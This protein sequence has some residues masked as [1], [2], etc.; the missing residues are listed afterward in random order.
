MGRIS[1]K[2]VSLYIAVMLS[3]FI[4]IS[5][6]EPITEDI[7]A[8]V[9]DEGAPTI[10]VTSPSNYSIYK[11]T[12][13]FTGTVND[14]ASNSIEQFY[15]SDRN[16]QVGGGVTINAGNVSQDSSEGDTPVSFNSSSGNFSFTFSTVD[17]EVL[18]R[19]LYV[20]IKAVDWNGNDVEE[21]I[22]LDPPDEGP[23]IDLT[24]P[25]A[26]TSYTDTI[27][28]SGFAMDEYDPLGSVTF[29]DMKY[30][31]WKINNNP[32]E[33]KIINLQPLSD[34]T[35]EHS[36][37]G[38]I[39]S[40]GSFS[41]DSTNGSFSDT[42]IMDDQQ[43]AKQFEFISE[44][45]NG[46]INKTSFLISDANVS[47][48]ITLDDSLTLPPE[49]SPD[50]RYFS[51]NSGEVLQLKGV[52]GAPLYEIEEATYLV[53]PGTPSGTISQN[54]LYDASG[55]FTITVP[56]NTLNDNITQTIRLKVQDLS[57][58]PSTIEF[59]YFERDD[60][61]PVIDTCNVSSASDYIDISISEPVWGDKYFNSIIT[62]S[63]LKVYRLSNSA[64][65]SIDSIT[66]LSDNALTGSE[67]HS[68][69]RIHLDDSDTDIL[70]DGITEFRIAA[71]STTGTD[72]VFDKANNL[73]T[74]KSFEF[75]D[76]KSPSV[77]ADAKTPSNGS[78]LSSNTGNIVFYMDEELNPSGGTRRIK[79]NGSDTGV[80][81]VS[82]ESANSR[83][84]IELAGV[85]FSEGENT[86]TVP[87]G[88]FED[89]A[90]NGNNA[91]IPE[92]KFT[93]D[94]TKPSLDEGEVKSPSHGSTIT[95]DNT[96]VVFYFDENVTASDGSANAVITL[97]GSDYAATIS[98]GN[99]VTASVTGLSDTTYT[100]GFNAGAF[101]DIA[102]NTCEA[103]S[104]TWDFTVDT[105]KPSLDEGEVKSPSHGSTIASDNTSV[106]FYFDENVTAS[107]G[108]ANAVIT[109]D[110]S[111]YAATISDGNKVTA[112][113]TGLLDTTYT[114]GFNA[115]AFKDI[116]GN[117]C[118]A[119]SGTW[120][121]T[122]DTKKPSL[123]EGEVKSPSH[124]STITT[125]NTSVVF[126][127]DE[128]VTASD[129]SADAVITL[130]GSDY[131][132]TIS[133][134]NKVTASVTGLSDTTYTVG[135]NAGTFKDIAGNTCEAYSGTWDFTVDATKPSLDEGEVKSPSHG[136]T[137]ASDNTSVVFYFDEN[138]TAS[139]G[140]AN[141][142]ITLDG[143]DYAATISDGNKVTASVTGLSDT[144]YTVGFN[145]GAFKDIVGNACEAY[146]GTWDFTVDTIPYV[147]ASSRSPLHNNRVNSLTPSITF[148]FDENVATGSGTN[149]GKVKI[150]SSYYSVSE[151]NGSVTVLL[152]DGTPNTLTDGT[153]Y[154]VEIDENAFKDRDGTE[155]F[156]AEYKNSW[157]FTVD[158]TAPVVGMK[159]PASGTV[160]Y[161]SSVSFEFNDADSQITDS[162]GGSGGSVV[163][164]G[165]TGITSLNTTISGKTVTVNTTPFASLA[166]GTYTVTISFPEGRYKDTAG[167]NCTALSGWTFSITR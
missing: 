91:Y 151:T 66:D 122:V 73:L 71:R 157:S 57:G 140:S 31:Q 36:S 156:C 100:V 20:I 86:L 82:Y 155:H 26:S 139:D 145:A 53:T 147:V 142:V 40:N 110:G 105:K 4:I 28:I 89:P 117:T 152:A 42:I 22:E 72:V 39:F 115:G 3:L 118:E 148:D 32:L 120:D 51:R 14:D 137:I 153:T 13:T 58:S 45:L 64:E 7:V 167:N 108:S 149:A 132:A 35:Y 23:Y 5:C 79:L 125:D 97:D 130:D 60:T 15:F 52:I 2:K 111:D 143:S 19:K 90:G 65:V 21:T 150:G 85:T 134:G 69:I 107:D 84:K 30:I 92:W 114:V 78:L 144:T 43:D 46:F 94:I 63:D 10:V 48:S 56:T 25:T 136:S 77:T 166:A 81:S 50:K 34:G 24:S 159:S 49:F 141:A 76:H 11:S 55:N 61:A 83:S 161:N 165:T 87:A 33:E 38:I 133:D 74:E 162:S 126:Y 93:V 116:A 121:F 41:Y 119:Y 18:D 88:V 70:K 12:V 29:N 75:P 138:V 16:K 106:F 131:A 103:Y 98:D 135:F 9:E 8:K 154:S 104:G 113:V 127:F 101:K 62:S 54:I 47:Q 67:G 99:K 128:N 6:P 59:E 109:L 124:G 146:S 68:V 163:V 96:S 160:A 1:F 95:T 27:D 158:T 112:S 123:D 80:C 102:G 44:N 164:S 129:G 37:D 17:P